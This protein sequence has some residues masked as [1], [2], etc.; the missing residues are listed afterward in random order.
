MIFTTAI[1][2]REQDRERVPLINLMREVIPSSRIVGAFEP[3]WEQAKDVRSI[4]GC[5]V[6]H[7]KAYAA[8]ANESTPHL[9]LEDDAVVIPDGLKELAELESLPDDCG[10][11]LVGSETPNIYKMGSF[12]EVVVPFHGAHGVLFNTPLLCKTHFL[13]HAWELLS[14]TEMSEKAC[15]F[16]GL[17]F[18][19][20]SRVGL[21][22]YRMDKMAFSTS[23]GIS[24][25]TGRVHGPRDAT[26][27]SSPKLATQQ[28]PYF[29]P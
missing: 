11:L 15:C 10:V 16:E 3:L 28:I 12:Y 27:I 26:P 21:R 29:T 2:H 22:V 9:N 23:G 5:S 25:R 8:I 14:T 17:L 13:M 4:R 18:A 1:I 7:L 6:S 19:A 24:S 20:C